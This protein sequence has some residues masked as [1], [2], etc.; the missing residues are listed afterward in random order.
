MF[1]FPLVVVFLVVRQVEPSYDKTGEFCG[2][3]KVDLRSYN[4]VNFALSQYSTVT[5]TLNSNF[6]I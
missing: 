2:K 4:W 3:I 1:F 5:V 6:A